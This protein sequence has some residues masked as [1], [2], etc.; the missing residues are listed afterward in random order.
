MQDVERSIGDELAVVDAT[1]EDLGAAA[2]RRSP[3]RWAVEEKARIV[4]ESFR[5]G[6]QV[7]EVARCNGIAP[8]RLSEWRSLA[9]QG[10]LA[11]PSSPASAE[12]GADPSFAALE[13][14]DAPEGASTPSA[15]TGSVAIEAGGVAVRI[16]G[17]SSVARIVEIAAALRGLR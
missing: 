14:E 16:G 17:D 10:R 3:R 8:R 4:R 5:P 11:V 15:S 1:G 6:K 7:G 13:V 12:P 2:K 9:R